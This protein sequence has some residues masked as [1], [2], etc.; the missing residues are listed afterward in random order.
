VWFFV[1][2][3]EARQRSSDE[4]LEDFRQ[5]G[6]STGP[7]DGLPAA[8]VYTATATGTES[9]GIPGLDESLGPNAPVTVTHG[10]DGCFTYRV[11]FNSH[12]YRTWTYCPTETASFALTGTES[13]SL[14]KFPGLDFSSLNTYTCESPLPW[15]WSDPVVGQRQDGRCTGTSDTIDGVTADAVSLEVLEVGTV[16]V[17]GSQVAAVKVRTTDT[18]TDAQRGTE[19]DEWWVDATTGL[20]LHLAI[21]SKI[22]SDTPVGT[23]DYTEHG[24]LELTTLQPAT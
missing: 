23:A 5:S 6:A 20:P 15:V 10:G 18:F 7:A 3:D 8:G 4:V 22:T 24:T 16:E 2:R 12:H 14:R 17:A 13:F 19:V 11:D 9:V 1:G 21:D